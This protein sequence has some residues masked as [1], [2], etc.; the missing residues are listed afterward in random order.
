MLL[1][2]NVYRFVQ[3]ICIP[4]IPLI[5]ICYKLLEH[6]L[7]NNTLYIRVAYIMLKYDQLIKSIFLHT[8]YKIKHNRAYKMS[9]IDSIIQCMCYLFMTVLYFSLINS[10]FWKKRKNTSSIQRKLKTF[11]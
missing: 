5:P 2:L 4:T 9:P 6:L 10:L 3:K 11:Y 7:S 8:H 1:Y